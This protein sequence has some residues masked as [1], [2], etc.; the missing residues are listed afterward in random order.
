MMTERCS[1]HDRHVRCAET[2]DLVAWQSPTDLTPRLLCPEHLLAAHAGAA[3]RRRLNDERPRI[4]SAGTAAA[5][6]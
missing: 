2:K 4:H 5:S 6:F 3:K 1:W